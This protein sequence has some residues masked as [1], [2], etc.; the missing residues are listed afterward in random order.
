M[1]KKIDLTGQR[2]GRLVVIEETKPFYS[3]GRKRMMW[4]CKCDCGN[5]LAVRGENLRCKNTM[6]C[7]C[8]KKERTRESNTKHGLTNSRIYYIWNS[9]LE[10]CNHPSCRSYKYYG[11]RGIKV[12]KQWRKFE[13]F[14]EWAMS[15][16]YREDL[17][18][19]RI[20]VNGNYEPSNCRWVDLYTQG[21]NKR[22]NRLV[23]IDGI[24][25]CLSQWM[26]IKGI[27]KKTVYSRLNRGWSIEDALNIP[28]KRK[29][30]EFR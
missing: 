8:Y 16:G 10:R 11:D 30:G 2:F 5:V 29:R 26:E 20:D 3:S 1:S 27:N 22:N 17:T 25:H 9:M 6:S 4:L 14:Y 18:I 15:N 13:P 23:T 24:T 19:D 12:C 21:R 28:I 7:G